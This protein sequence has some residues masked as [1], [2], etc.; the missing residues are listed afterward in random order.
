MGGRQDPL[1]TFRRAPCKSR[2]AGHKRQE[3][4]RSRSSTDT[5][6]HRPALGLPTALLPYR[7]STQKWARVLVCLRGLDGA[8]HQ[9]DKLTAGNLLSLGSEQLPTP[10]VTHGKAPGLATQMKATLPVEMPPPSSQDAAALA[11]AGRDHF[12]EVPKAPQDAHRVLQGTEG[13]PNT[14]CL[15]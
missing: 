10:L 2:V 14:S 5:Q 3:Q 15:C 4:H 7:S 1:L 11:H 13:P 12:T 9:P 8:S 6:G